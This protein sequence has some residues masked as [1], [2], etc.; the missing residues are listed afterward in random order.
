MPEQVLKQN[1]YPLIETDRLLLT[2]PRVEDAARMLAYVEE[3]RAHLEPWSPPAPEGYYTQK[4]WREHFAQAR[5]D[6]VEG[7][8]MRLVLFERANVTGRV[9]GVCN[10]SNIMRG[11]FQA[12]FLGYHLDGRDVGRGLMS[13]ALTA[14][15]AYA[16]ERLRLHRVMANYIPRNERSGRVLRR[17]GFTVEGYARDYLLINGAWEDHIL[18]AL[19]NHKL[20]FVDGEKP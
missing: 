8:S 17:L 12:C 14:A 16:F 20:Q 11:P 18:T 13:E 15:I 6:F 10:F 5:Q 2:M 1:E 7:R 9:V 19:T 4:F 3:N